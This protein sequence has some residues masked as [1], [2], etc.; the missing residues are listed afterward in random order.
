V[1]GIRA[2]RGVPDAPLLLSLFALDGLMEGALN[3]FVVV[4]A[5]KV[6]GVG[7]E[8]VGFLA[9]VETV[10]GL[11]GG[12]FAFNAVH[13]R[14]LG[15]RW[16]LMGLADAVPPILLAAF[17]VLGVVIAMLLAWEAIDTLDEAIGLELL[18][19]VVPEHLMPSA[20][21]LEDGV[22]TMSIAAGAIIAP[23][24]VVL[25]GVRG[26][27]LAIGLV[28]P[29]VVLATL[30]GF[31]RIDKRTSAAFDTERSPV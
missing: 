17:P 12:L 24:L 20:L 22:I 25:L 9:A 27:L 1:E 23:T 14:G 13:V 26:G 21:G 6:L 31:R 8:G 7:A 29:V 30:R 18:R 19:R 15:V 2:L 3:V 5:L 28:A 11:V 16:T 4:L 10:G